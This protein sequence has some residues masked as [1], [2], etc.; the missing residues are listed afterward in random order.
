MALTLAF[1]PHVTSGA[2]LGMA[3]A[4]GASAALTSSAVAVS[5]WMKARE[6]LAAPRCAD[7]FT[8]DRA[9][10]RVETG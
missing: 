5:A 8:Y 7:V 10:A 6:L 1:A 9:F 3:K 2:L 4:A